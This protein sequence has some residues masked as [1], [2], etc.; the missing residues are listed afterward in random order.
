[1]TCS[2]EELVKRHLEGDEQSFNQL[3]ERYAGRLYSLAYRVLLDHSG[4][5]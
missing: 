4:R 3:V 5:G 2:D 1:M